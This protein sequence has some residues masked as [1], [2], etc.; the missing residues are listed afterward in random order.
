MT[1]RGDESGFLLAV[2]PGRD[3]TGLALLGVDGEI[4]ARAIVP[5]S[6]VG[7][8]ALE[9]VRR[10]SPPHL[11]VGRGTGAGQA[12]RSLRAVGLTFELADERGTTL[13][14]RA[15]YFAE[16]PPRGWRRLVPLSLQIPPVPIDDYAAARIG[17]KFLA[18]RHVSGEGE[19]WGHVGLLEERSS[20]HAS[21]PR[22]GPT[23]CR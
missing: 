2:D 11:I 18:E 17:Q 9:W 21:E 6:E 4:L 8:R 3:K 14:A 15:L 10:W 22:P 16:H 19:A 13:A 20:P 7:T 12:R 23:P 1:P 5:A